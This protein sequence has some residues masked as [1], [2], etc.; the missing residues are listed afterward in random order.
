MSVM[1]LVDQ[2]TSSPPACVHVCISPLVC[3]LCVEVRF[4][5]CGHALIGKLA[6]QSPAGHFLLKDPC[7]T[8]TQKTHKHTQS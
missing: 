1:A 3:V 5:F 4:A 8:H 6:T 7:H 2:N